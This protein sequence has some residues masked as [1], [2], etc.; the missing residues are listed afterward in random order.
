MKIC[1]I[2]GQEFKNWGR[3]KCCSQECVRVH[4]NTYQRKYKRDNR[5]KDKAWAR[6]SKQKNK[7]RFLQSYQ[8]YNR[9]RRGTD[10]SIA[11]KMWSHINGRCNNPS[12][13]K[14][15]RYGGRGIRNLLSFDFILTL[16]YNAKICPLCC[17]EFD[18]EIWKRKKSIDRV[19]NNG[20]YEESNVRI[21]CV[22]CNSKRIH[23][24]NELG[25]CM[26]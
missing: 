17:V 22:S 1:I 10:Y 4:R 24:E 18:Y 16:V 20:H 21:I 11:Q 14:Y 26:R 9:K 19:E 23:V 7:E 15:P 6:K 5:E 25:N 13:P 2:C 8:N 12:D 3:Q